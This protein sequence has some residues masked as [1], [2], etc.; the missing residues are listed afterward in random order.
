LS[1]I[2]HD[3][4]A[5]TVCG[6][7]G[8]VCASGP[9]DESRIR[10][11]NASLRH[12]GPDAE[13]LWRSGPAIL[14]HRRLSIIDLSPMGNQ[15]LLNEDETIGVV[16]NGEIYD[17]EAL[18]ADLQRRG[19]TFR[20]NSD[21]EVLL[22][23][24]ED[25]GLDFVQAVF[26]M[27]AFALW[28]SRRQRLVLGRDRAG[29]KPLYYR[30]TPDGGI[31][32]ASQ[33]QAIL[34]AFPELP[35]ELDLESIDEYLTLQ[36]VPSPRTAYR[37]MHKLEAA[38]IAVFEPGKDVV[39]R[40]Y[41]SKPSGPELTGKTEDLAAELL[42]LVSNAVRRR[43]VADVP[44]GAF[45]SGGLDSSTVVGLMARHSN[46]PVQTF[47]IG[48]PDAADSEL[49]WA[50]TVAAKFGTVH[51]EATIGPNVMDILD[52]TLR[53]FGEPFADS[54][55]VATYWVSRLARE[56]VKVALSGDGSDEA[57][58]GYTRYL[59]AQM[60]HLHDALPGLL[61]AGYRRGLR[62]G[63]AIAAPHIA[64][65]IDHFEDG[66]AVRYP[67]IMC[68]FTPEEKLALREPEAWALITSARSAT[69]TNG[70]TSPTSDRFRRVLTESGRRSQLARLIDLDW[71]T[72]LADDINPK[73][74]VASMA[75]ALEVRCPFLDTEVVE[76]AARLPRNM[77]M[78]VLGKHLLRR[79][80]ADVVPREV[81]RRTK[82]GFG[83]PLRR[84]MNGELGERAREVLLDRTARERGLFRVREVER[85]LGAMGRER[86][87]P[88][89]VW[90]LLVLELWLR[91]CT[92]R[93]FHVE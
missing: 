62:A 30:R 47:S 34:Q 73:V 14:G 18:R 77:L 42:H 68:Q 12:R 4:R 50:R 36:Y 39:V 52:T 79:A 8:L 84:W 70:V 44:V 24:Y 51:H 64:G 92:P 66:E 63:V 71:S 10:R 58:A 33:P 72:Y 23:L 86:N 35:V 11:A 76:F 15:P 3:W 20:S 81:R 29:K 89:R 82:R 22:H 6:I 69:G 41:W 83:L 19:H 37:G 32:F 48:F 25:R 7:S 61:R 49:P 40:R 55:A 57:F 67:Y 91:R 59:T 5:T 28:D 38:R 90:T 13:G 56:H 53:Q 17:H 21:S 1:Y 26:G 60:G 9:P 93:P 54:S 88:D 16:V 65:Y 43:M 78:R 27:F 75:H 74:D 2:R 31:A 45:L 80:V 87:A 46:R 85:L